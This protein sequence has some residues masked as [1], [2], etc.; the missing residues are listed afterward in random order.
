MF[1]RIRGA[2]IG[3]TAAATGATAIVGLV[4]AAA[5]AKHQRHDREACQEISHGGSLTRFAGV[6]AIDY[7]DACIE[8]AN[9]PSGCTVWIISR[10]T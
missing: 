5:D 1:V 10:E 8:S 9:L 7:S 6:R 4:P 2:T 3:A